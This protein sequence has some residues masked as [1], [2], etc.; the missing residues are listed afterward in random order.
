[1][2]GLMKDEARRQARLALSKGD[3][4]QQIGAD[5]VLEPNDSVVAFDIKTQEG[6]D[7]YLV[8]DYTA[9]RPDPELQNMDIAPASPLREGV[10]FLK[11]DTV[12]GRPI[13]FQYFYKEGQL[14]S[15]NITTPP[16]SVPMDGEYLET[17]TVK[18]KAGHPIIFTFQWEKGELKGV[19]VEPATNPFGEVK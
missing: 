12:E 2:P 15:I 3:A 5:R 6:E 14:V 16:P 8:A 7:L 11:I 1:M 10:K 18:S 19:R 17:L 9:R 13:E 4:V